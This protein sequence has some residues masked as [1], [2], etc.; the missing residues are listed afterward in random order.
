[1]KSDLI[2]VTGPCA[3]LRRSRGRRRALIRSR[4]LFLRGRRPEPESA[5]AANS[6]RPRPPPPESG[7]A[8]VTVDLRDI[9]AKAGPQTVGFR[10]PRLDQWTRIF[11]IQHQPTRMTPVGEFK[12]N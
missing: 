2:D 7:A 4:S 9:E 1:M 11:S 10:N 12:P 8:A 3:Y 5:A 6:G